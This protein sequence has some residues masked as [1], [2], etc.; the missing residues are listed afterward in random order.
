MEIANPDYRV[1]LTK[2]RIYTTRYNKTWPSLKILLVS[3]LVVFFYG[4]KMKITK[5]LKQARIK[6]KQEKNYIVADKLEL[7][8]NLVNHHRIKRNATKLINS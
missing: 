5:E 2:P 8:I 6:A 1:Y 4:A 3:F 7:I